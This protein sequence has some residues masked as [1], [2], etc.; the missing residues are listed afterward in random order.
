MKTSFWRLLAN[1]LLLALV[2]GLV[3]ACAGWLLGWKASVQ[4]SNGFFGVGGILIVI[5]ILSVMGGFGG[6]AD[7]HMLF[8][9]SAGSM[10]IN[11]RNQR[12]VSDMTQGYQA[13]IFLFLLGGFLVALAVL[14][15][16]VF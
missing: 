16:N 10:D 13:F 3:V 9:Q 6:R 7:S 15:A 14:T 11:E 8:S 4:Y 1:T 2:I 5:G 12:L